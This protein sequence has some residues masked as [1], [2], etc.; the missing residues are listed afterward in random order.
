MVENNKKFFLLLIF[1]LLIGFINGL[2]GGG[3][4]MLCV[5]ALKMLF[6]TD[7]KQAH[8]TSILVTSILSISTLIV[9]ITTL[10]LNFEYVPFLSVGVLVGGVV[11]SVLLNKFS[12][13]TLSII[14]VIVMLVAGIK[15]VVW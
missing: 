5:P 14:F 6:N 10:Q 12:N 2:L 11:G 13:K 9:Y 4:G 15:S 8:A 1:S 3:A 7:A